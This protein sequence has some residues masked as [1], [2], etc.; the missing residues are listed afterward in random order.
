LVRYVRQ[1][2]INS[3]KT[4]HGGMPKLFFCCFAAEIRL[5]RAESTA[6]TRKDSSTRRSDA[7]PIR[8]I[9]SG[10]RKGEGHVKTAATQ[11]VFHRNL[12]GLPASTPGFMAQLA[13]PEH[14]FQLTNAACRALIGGRDVVGKPLG[15]ALPET[16]P[17][18][19]V[20]ATA[21]AR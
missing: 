12:T 13:G 7:A 16:L 11:I 2:H 5:F 19:I 21:S 8:A 18:G 10:R 6:S 17:H 9:G 3:G 14:M 20:A 4:A 15:D 1:K